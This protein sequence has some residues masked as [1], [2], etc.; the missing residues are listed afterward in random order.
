MQRLKTVYNSKKG[1]TLV[2]LVCVIAIL[3]VLA[4]VAIPVVQSTMDTSSLR[5]A[6]ADAQTIENCIKTAKADIQSKTIDTYG[7]KAIDG[8]VSIA[9]VIN[10]RSIHSACQSHTFRNQQIVPVWDNDTGEVVLVFA[11]DNVNVESNRTVTDFVPLTSTEDTLIVNL[12]K[13]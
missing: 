13:C 11:S 4:A 3:S 7:E 10:A 2:E 6:L 9:D 5:T 12:K 8:D 1:F